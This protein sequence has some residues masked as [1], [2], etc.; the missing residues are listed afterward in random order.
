MFPSNFVK[1]IDDSTSKAVPIPIDVAKSETKPNEKELK[2]E[3][4]LIRFDEKPPPAVL[5]ANATPHPVAVEEGMIILQGF[6]A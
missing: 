5:S 3:D 1:I 4:E 2:K 6:H